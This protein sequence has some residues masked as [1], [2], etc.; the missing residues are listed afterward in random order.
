MLFTLCLAANSSFVFTS[1]QSGIFRSD[2]SGQSWTNVLNGSF[3]YSRAIATFGSIVLAVTGSTVMRSTDN[4][5]NWTTINISGSGNLSIISIVDQKIFAGSNQV[6]EMYISEDLGKTWQELSVPLL[7]ADVKQIVGKDSFVAAGLSND[8]GVIVSYDSGKHWMHYNLNL[9]NSTIQSLL[10]IDKK[11][12]AGTW[13]SGVFYV[14]TG[15]VPTVNDLVFP[16]TGSTNNSTRTLLAWNAIPDATTYQLQISKKETFDSLIVDEPDLVEPS[17]KISVF[18]YS[19]KYY[20][21]VRGKALTG[22]IWPWVNSSFETMQQP[23]HISLHQNYPNPFRSSTQ[24]RFDLPSTTTVT[25]KIFNLLGQLVTTLASD[26]FLDGTNI[27]TWNSARYSSGVYFLTLQTN[28][29]QETI[30]MLILK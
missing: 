8:G 24:I 11:L 2:Y 7:N 22:Y 12:Y 3:Q 28:E 25:I 19:T 10:F 27:L 15:I 30:K 13:G 21:R 17:K 6:N 16:E 26:Y 9:S 23:D 5:D 14:E 29:S 1:N 20:W 4:G 18:D